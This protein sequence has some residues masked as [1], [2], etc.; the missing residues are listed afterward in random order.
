MNLNIII[1]LNNYIMANKTTIN[2]Y[3]S[4]DDQVI[5]KPNETEEY[6]EEESLDE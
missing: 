1:Q 6:S 3:F 2:D 5:D 4:D